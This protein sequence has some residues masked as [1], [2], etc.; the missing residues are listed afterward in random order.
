MHTEDKMLHCISL[1]LTISSLISGDKVESNL[2][3]EV[4]A[5]K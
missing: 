1:C 2:P 3:H 4:R 5:L